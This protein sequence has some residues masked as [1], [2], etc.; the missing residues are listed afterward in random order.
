[1]GCYRQ[2]WWIVTVDG[3]TWHFPI[4]RFAWNLADNFTQV[5]VYSGVQ[6]FTSWSLALSRPVTSLSLTSS[7]LPWSLTWWLWRIKCLPRVWP[8][9]LVISNLRDSSSYKEVCMKTCTQWAVQSSPSWTSHK[10]DF[11]QSSPNVI[12]QSS[13]SNST[14][15]CPRNILLF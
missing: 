10:T 1:M 11:W 12:S 6:P 13:N 8:M 7:L 2:N 4:D 15:S 14:S 9:F 5:K 3:Q